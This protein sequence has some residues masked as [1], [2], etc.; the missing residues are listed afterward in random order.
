MK[1][2]LSDCTQNKTMFSLSCNKVAISFCY[3]QYCFRIFATSP[4]RSRFSYCKRSRISPN[5]NATVKVRKTG[6]I[7]FIICLNFN[8]QTNLLSYISKINNK[9]Y[10]RILLEKFM[11]NITDLN[12]ER[13]LPLI[14]FTDSSTSITFAHSSTSIT[15]VKRSCD[16]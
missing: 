9:Y 5:W 10:Y 4:Y 1:N 12:D 13:Y 8:M 14:K 7:L 11:A 16:R 6:T 2:I 3:I 15:F